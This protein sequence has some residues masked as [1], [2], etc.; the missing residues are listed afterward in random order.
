MKKNKFKRLLPLI[1]SASLVMSFTPWPING[2]IG[3][4]QIES[5]AEET[6]PTV[7]QCKQRAEELQLEFNNQFDVTGASEVSIDLS[8]YSV[9]PEELHIYNN[10]VAFVKANVVSD[11]QNAY[12]NLFDAIV[13]KGN[14]TRLCLDMTGPGS[15]GT[16]GS[17][18]LSDAVRYLHIIDDNNGGKMPFYV[19]DGCKIKVDGRTSL[20]DLKDC[21]VLLTDTVWGIVDFEGSITNSSVY[22]YN[23]S[24]YLDD[25]RNI[26]NSY[27]Y[28]ND[29][30]NFNMQNFNS[31][32][33]YLIYDKT[34]PSFGCCNY[35]KDEIKI[36]G[37]LNN[38]SKVYIQLFE[39]SAVYL[40]DSVFLDGNITRE[41]LSNVVPNFSYKDMYIQCKDG[42]V[43]GCLNCSLYGS[44]VKPHVI[45]SQFNSH[46]D[47][48]VTVETY[49]YPASVKTSI[50]YEKIE[51]GTQVTYN[52]DT[53]YLLN[54]GTLTCNYGF[55]ITINDE[56]LYMQ[57]TVC[58]PHV[59]HC[60][61][62]DYIKN[63]K[64]KNNML[65]LEDRGIYFHVAPCKVKT[66]LSNGYHNNVAC[67]WNG[68]MISSSNAW[69]GTA[70]TIELMDGRTLT[71]YSNNYAIDGGLMGGTANMFDL[72]TNVDDCYIYVYKQCDGSSKELV[73][74]IEKVFAGN[75]ELD[76]FYIDSDN[77][78]VYFRKDELREK[79]HNGKIPFFIVSTDGYC[80]TSIVE[81][82][83]I[84]NSNPAVLPRELKV[85]RGV[86]DTADYSVTYGTGDYRANTI[87]KVIIEDSE[88]IFSVNGDTLSIQDLDE[89]QVGTHKVT[90]EFDTGF[91]A[92][93]S[94]TIT[95]SQMGVG[96]TVLPPE[97]LTMINYEFYKDYPDYVVIPIRLNAATGVKEIK[98]G[99]DIVERPNWELQDN[100]IVL[101]P[102]YLS[103]L[104]A[105]KYRVLPKFNDIMETIISNIRLVIYDNVAD[106]GAP[107]LL[108]SVI[109]FMGQNL[110]L[111]FD[112]GYGETQANDVLALVLDDNL[113]L[114]NGDVVPFSNSKVR[115]MKRAYNVVEEEGTSVI[116]DEVMD[117]EPIQVASPSNI[118]KASPSNISKATPSN[119][120]EATPSSIT[121][122]N[123]KM[124]TRQVKKI[125]N[126]ED[127]LFMAM[128]DL[129][130]STDNVFHVEGD[131]IC[132]DGSYVE[133]LGLSAGDHLIGAIFDNTEKTTDIKKVVLRI[134]E[135]KDDTPDNPGG[136]H[137]PANPNPGDDD[138]S[139]KD[140]PVNPNPGGGNDN[141]DNPGGGDGPANETDPDKNQG[142]KPGVGTGSGNKPSGGNTGIISGG[143]SRPSGGSSGGSSGGGSRPSSSGSSSNGYGPGST[144]NGSGSGSAIL[145]DGSMNAEFKPAVT[146]T[147]GS[148]EGSGQDWQFKKADGTYAKGEWIGSKGDWY[149]IG[150]DGKM[151]FDW[152]LDENGKWYML[153]KD[154]GARFGAALYGW[155]FEKQDGKWYFMNP[156]DTAMLVG[157]Q[158]INGKW[159]YL[160]QHNDAPTYE[161]DNINGWIYNGKSKPCGSMYVNETTPDGYKVGSDGAWIK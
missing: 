48:F 161:G 159:Y 67:D 15:G 4:G 155:Y 54:D 27:F 144:A 65:K 86:F 139:K 148:W 135:E 101:S 120:S 5:R 23:Q 100:A 97:A 3:F 61:F 119:A 122:V 121:I 117:V 156:S 25:V 76:N 50:P 158:F 102:L 64:F 33:D 21:E 109:E 53:D 79:L 78:R 90:I 58:K 74:N 62:Y 28:I 133:S 83:G 42:H 59:E 68:Y 12:S 44:N 124:A 51:S 80:L 150:A 66:I 114:P 82:D 47:Q 9:Q 96:D 106:R 157:W 116:M 113:I 138:D 37:D 10:G 141:P 134:P 137:E 154:E 136:G 127:N 105:G 160:T 7:E 2:G 73:P 99:T 118:G 30:D 152:F 88:R 131:E 85:D 98:I 110:R 26:E 69:N 56:T 45:D 55:D 40:P 153:N 16:R 24:I 71:I 29:I 132:L 92:I 8:A 125:R 11:K 70:S 94:L 13:R 31:Y 107:Y 149:Y 129:A 126:V 22:S 57:F 39:E 77:K 19:G 128:A 6:V 38:I 20:K 49:G 151:K 147:P 75:I 104:D 1:L 60:D 146:E 52:I 81:I 123:D 130:L 140:D 36:Y 46:S 34:C 108:Q 91:K 35:Y 72:N 111:R 14:V 95:D 93:C 17:H 63:D 89:L 84:K 143:S 18:T 112:K 103:T 41:E 145:P 43:H 87:D 32:Q 115:S 142:N